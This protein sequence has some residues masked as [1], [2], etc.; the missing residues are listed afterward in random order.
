MTRPREL[1]RFARD[2]H[3]ALAYLHDPVHLQTHPLGRFVGAEPGTSPGQLGRRLRQWIIDTIEGLQPGPE[4]GEGAWRPHRLL[5]LRYVEAMEPTA[6]QRALGIAKSQYYVEHAR[7]VRAVVSLLAARASPHAAAADEPGTGDAPADAPLAEPQPLPRPL[8]SFVGREREVAAAAGQLLGTDPGGRPSAPVRLLTL[9]GPPGTGKTR[10]ALRLAAALAERFA[11]GVFFV[12]LGSLTDPA[13]VLPTIAKTLGVRE[14]PASPLP[15]ALERALRGRRLLLVLDNFEQLLD[16]APAIG[17]LLAAGDGV[18][19]LVTSRERLRVYGERE[20][21]VPP[22]DLP[23]GAAASLGPDVAESPAVRL[24]VERARDA[25]LDF[26]LTEENAA[27]VAA[28]CRR[29]D[30][31]PLAIE[32]AAARTRILSPAAILARLDRRLALL[33]GGP[34]DLPPRQRTLRAAIDWSYRLLDPDEQSLFRRLAVFVGGCTLEGAAAVAG[35]DEPLDRLESL[36]AK[37]LLEARETADGPRFGM[38]LTVRELAREEL[39]ASGEAEAVKRRH[40]EHFLRLAEAGEADLRGG[41]RQA[42]WLDRLEREHDNLRAALGWCVEQRATDLGLRLGGV[43]WRFW[44]VR[45]YA[46]EGREH[47][48]AL[49]RLADAPA[50]PAARAKVLN[51]AGALAADLGDSAAARGFLAESLAIRRAIG[52]EE[53]VASTLANLGTEA[54]RRGVT[55]AARAFFEESLALRRRLGPARAVAASLSQLGNVA[56]LEE[57]YA[58]AT[59]LFEESLAGFEAAGSD[60]DVGSALGNLGFVALARGDPAAARRRLE[61]SLELWQRLGY[62]RGL[63]MLLLGFAALSAHEGH[64]RRALRLVGAGSALLATTGSALALAERTTFERCIAVARRAL[65]PAEEA[66]LAEGRALTVAAAIR[67][68]LTGEAESDDR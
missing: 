44:W 51:G 15:D 38:L 8:T 16:A 11:D 21:H 66:A 19:A 37:S 18:Q 60:W 24:F 43:L 47:L 45:G 40:A 56:W 46:A 65:G 9:T 36:V 2:V 35:L 58:A 63:A 50:H 17:R 27:A 12:P 42:L 22:L 48:A 30:G 59:A 57:D 13:L 31:L 20:L 62:R 29:L 33:T 34:Q 53:G 41:Q 25:R 68:A 6:V 4:S 3:D 32:L 55:G 26:A 64:A 52:D 7:A 23:N 67:E 49:L 28:I 54:M 1:S 61:E 14:T 39:G 5:R 10:L